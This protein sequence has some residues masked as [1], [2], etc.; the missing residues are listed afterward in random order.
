MT[1]HHAYGEIVYERVSSSL[2]DIGISSDI[3]SRIEVGTWCGGRAIFQIIIK[4]RKC[5]VHSVGVRS[6][7]PAFI[8]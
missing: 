8:E 2:Q 1:R 4:G 7:V 3:V 6:H 5:G